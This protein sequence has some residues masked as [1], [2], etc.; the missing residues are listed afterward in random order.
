MTV[1][2][3]KLL[4]SYKVAGATGSTYV[5]GY[6]SAADTV[7]RATG[8]GAMMVGIIENNPTNASDRASVCFS[9]MTKARAG[10][11]AIVRGAVLTSDANGHVVTQTNAATS[12]S[13]GIAEEASTAYGQLI[14]LK[15][16]PL[17]ARG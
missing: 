17:P 12:Y 7:A 16:N 2:G 14:A 13:V 9:G 15:V 6:Q 3:E 8:T 1:Q 11:A 10:T 5:V 4:K